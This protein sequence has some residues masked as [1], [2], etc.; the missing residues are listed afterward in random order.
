MTPGTVSSSAWLGDFGLDI[1]Y[2]VTGLLE[3][4]S[5]GDAVFVWCAR[6]CLFVLVPLCLGNIVYLTNALIGMR[7][8]AKED[9]RGNK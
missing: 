4:G 2:A 3:D 9:K 8:N 5:P 1:R 7:R 6:V